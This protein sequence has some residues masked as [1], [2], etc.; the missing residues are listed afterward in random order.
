MGSIEILGHFLNLLYVVAFLLKNMIW[1]RVF[2]ISAASIEVFYSYHIAEKPLYVNIIW[3]SIWIVVNIVQLFLLI[4]EKTDL[5]LSDEESKIY[6]LSF[7]NFS[8]S[9]FKKLFAQAKWE[10]IEADKIIIKKNIVINELYLI[11]T[12]VAKVKLEN[13]TEVY[14]R[15]GNFI[16]EMSF[17]SGKTTTA[18]VYS[19]TEMRLLK[20]DRDVI[21]KLGAKYPEIDEGLKTSFNKDLVTKLIKKY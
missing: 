14:L 13:N 7:S 11:F 9:Y 17:I 21:Y 3:C 6:S 4:K 10:D 20:W 19:V 18:D 12:G 15:D 8:I 1:L 16:G 2:V 5:R